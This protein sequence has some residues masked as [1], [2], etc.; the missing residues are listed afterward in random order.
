MKYREL[1]MLL[2]R[3]FYRHA[4]HGRQDFQWTVWS[5]MERKRKRTTDINSHTKVLPEVEALATQVGRWGV[6]LGYKQVHG[7]IW[8]HLYLSGVGMDAGTILRR[9]RI[10][11]AL[12]SISLK[13]LK[14]VGAVEI[15]GKSPRHTQLFRAN[16]DILAILRAVL[17]TRELPLLEGLH[18]AASRLAQVSEAGQVE[19]MVNP[20][21]STRLRE[22]LAGSRDFL[23]NVLDNSANTSGS[24][25][26]L[27]PPPVG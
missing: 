3:G 25:S 6:N 16:P 15:A 4:V 19:G 20:L 27:V 13:D 18:A 21:R 10:S 17:R 14:A 5:D 9:L 24:I 23:K 22:F 26:G 12:V 8:C 7:R 11:K 2:G 1:Q